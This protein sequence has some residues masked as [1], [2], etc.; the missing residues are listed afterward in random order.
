MILDEEKLI[1]IAKPYLEKC[2]PG[3]LNHALRV[4][5]WVKT[6]GKNRK[7]IGLL[8]SAAYIHDLGWFGLVSSEFLDLDEMLKL[9]SK[10]N[11]NTEKMV[12]LVLGKLNFNN[13]EIKTVIRLIGAADKHRSETEDEEIIV[14]ADNLSKLC[15]GHL[16]EKYKPESYN[17]LIIR[18]E[19]ELAKRIKTA[20]GKRCYPL[21][22]DKLKKEMKKKV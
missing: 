2:R 10:A 7:D 22:L 6:L 1:S 3:D 14:D 11:E 8:I 19:G 4:V 15:I 12:K 16:K 18:L 20:E 9:E 13:E 5:K 21:L 17:K